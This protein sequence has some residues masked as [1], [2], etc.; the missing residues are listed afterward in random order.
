MLARKPALPSL[1][2]STQTQSVAWNRL[3]RAAAK[4]F[5]SSVSLSLPQPQEGTRT[6]RARRGATK[7]KRWGVLRSMHCTSG[8]AQRACPSASTSSLMV[9]KV[10]GCFVQ[11]H[12]DQDQ[13][14]GH[15]P[16]PSPLSSRGGRAGQIHDSRP[17]ETNGGGAPPPER[18]PPPPPPP[19]ARSPE[20]R[21]RAALVCLTN[22]TT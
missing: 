20:R 1:Y 3:T 21:R 17:S 11:R 6:G 7:D 12:H 13:D 9:G 8:A 18:P 10:V 15:A 14:Q 2:C 5:A 4:I 19:P 16:M 22:A